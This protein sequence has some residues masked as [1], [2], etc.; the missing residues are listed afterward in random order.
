MTITVSTDGSAL[1]NPNGAMGWAWADHPEDGTHEASHPHPGDSDAGGATNG[2]NQIGELCAVLEAL[3]AHTGS[4]PLIIETDSQYAINCSTTWLHGWKKNGWKNA[5]KKPV[6]NVELIKAIDREIA[7]RPGKVSFVW[8]K[9]HAGNAGNE[10]V[11][12]LAHSYASDCRS[13]VQDGYLPK[14]GWQSLQSSEYSQSL[15][16]P[17]DAV[18]LLSGKIS[19]EQYHLGRV[20]VEKQTEASGF[21]QTQKL[22]LEERL[23]EPEGYGKNISD[24]TEHP[25]D[26]TVEKQ[27][28]DSDHPNNHTVSDNQP[29]QSSLEPTEDSAHIQG[30]SAAS[31][32]PEVSEIS[33]PSVEQEPHS[34]K[35]SSEDHEEGET[36]TLAV[37]SVPSGLNVSGDLLFTPP[38]ASS[39]SYN[40][41]PRHI[42]GYIDI[43]GYVNGDGT[44]QFVNSPFML[45]KI[46]TATTDGQ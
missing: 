45:R 11:D 21:P 1:A 37:T 43:D 30:V 42:K 4:E 14:E 41:K 6:K 35:E 2:T 10:K 36:T 12:E 24:A 38:L 34:S 33:E 22:S 25:I 13:G 3:R 46:D 18:L 28:S 17:D 39:P 8:V 29:V 40:G 9:G 26:S 15:E 32:S 44:M 16:I 7:Q 23:S 19:D 5:Q 31:E 27:D 20:D